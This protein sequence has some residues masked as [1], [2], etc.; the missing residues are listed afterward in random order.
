MVALEAVAAEVG[1]VMMLKDIRYAHTSV[2]IALKQDPHCRCQ[3]SLPLRTGTKLQNAGLEHVEERLNPTQMLAPGS[4]T[5]HRS[6]MQCSLASKM[7]LVYLVGCLKCE[8][9]RRS[10]HQLLYCLY[11]IVLKFVVMLHSVNHNAE[12]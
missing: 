1:A 4:P 5:W 6:V 7:G 9:S 2:K 11:F 10:T 12:H 8:A 3:R